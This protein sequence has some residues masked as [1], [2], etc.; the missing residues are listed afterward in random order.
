MRNYLKE[1]RFQNNLTQVEL[2]EHIGIRPNYYSMIEN[3]S[4]QKNISMT[5]LIKLAAAFNVPVTQ[6]IEAENK[7]I[8]SLI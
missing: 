5:L 4:R 6:L 1:L 7:V 3:G 2:C 8:S